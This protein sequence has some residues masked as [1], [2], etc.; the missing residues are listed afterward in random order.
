M[1]TRC[2][3][4]ADELGGLFTCVTNDRHER[5]RTPFLYPDGDNI[6]LFVTEKDGG[7]IVSDLGE[8]LRWLRSQT[9]SPKRTPKQNALIADVCLTHGIEQFRGMLLARCRPG[10]TL[11]T[12]TLR[13]AQACLRVSDLWFTFRT[14]AVESVA[15]EVSDFLLEREI[16]FDRRPKMVG[17]SGRGWT[18]DFH[19][20]LPERGSLVSVLSTGNRS[21]AR[22]VAEHTL[23]MWHDLNQLTYGPEALRLISLFDD[24]ADVWQ[25]ED[26]TLLDS[27]SE[28]RRWSEP[29]TFIEALDAVA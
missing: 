12:V 6:D 9:L 8:T 16:R 27:L 28:V 20:I 15:D 22:P 4:L 3:T 17:R 7:L 5:I 10:M 29:E 21:S 24:T 13:V 26:F 2:E 25:D 23:A 14:R 18:P 11:A 19:V 1:T